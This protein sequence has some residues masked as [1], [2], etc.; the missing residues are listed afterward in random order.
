MYQD[1]KN[2]YHNTFYPDESQTGRTVEAARPTVDE[3]LKQYEQSQQNQNQ[4]GPE[5]PV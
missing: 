3:Q 4:T 5:G 1:D 2:L